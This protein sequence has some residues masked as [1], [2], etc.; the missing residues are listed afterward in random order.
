MEK[1]ITKIVAE[2]YKNNVYNYEI[3]FDNLELKDIISTSNQIEVVDYFT[4]QSIKEQLII[5][6]SLILFNHLQSTFPDIA[7]N[8][9]L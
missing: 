8:Y 1:L 9:E 7:K 2:S 6:S 4:L 5:D 3:G